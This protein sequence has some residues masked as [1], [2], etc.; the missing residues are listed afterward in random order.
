MAELAPDCA[1]MEK[2]DARTPRKQ[3]TLE[4]ESKNVIY[5]MLQNMQYDQ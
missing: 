3:Q 1:P 4:M 2:L 5:I